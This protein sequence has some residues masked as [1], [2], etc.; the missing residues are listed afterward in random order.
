MPQKLPTSRTLISSCG[1]FTYDSTSASIIESATGLPGM[2]RVAASKHGPSGEMKFNQTSRSIGAPRKVACVVLL[3]RSSRHPDA[4]P[5]VP[6]PISPD[7][8]PER[9]PQ[10]SICGLAEQAHERVA[11]QAT[12]QWGFIIEAPAR[13]PPEMDYQIVVAFLPHDGDE[14]L[15]SLRENLETERPVRL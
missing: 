12:M 1:C 10:A 9:E 2:G 6:S 4:A 13:Q 5:A 8:P 3:R 15:P 14:G 11:H 7:Q